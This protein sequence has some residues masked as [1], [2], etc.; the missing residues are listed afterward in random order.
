MFKNAVTNYTL[1]FGPLQNYLDHVVFKTGTRQKYH[2]YKDMM[3]FSFDHSAKI[4]NTFE[5]TYMLQSKFLI[6]HFLDA[7]FEKVC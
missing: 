3:S 4:L 7:N 5:L 1:K 6:P 2:V